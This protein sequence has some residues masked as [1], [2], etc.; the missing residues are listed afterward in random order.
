MLYGYGE[1]L[2]TVGGG[3]DATVAIGLLLIGVVLFYQATVVA[4]K[5]LIPLHRTE[6]GGLQQCRGHGRRVFF[7]L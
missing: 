1:G 6:I 3:N 4:V 5:L 2:Q 7:R